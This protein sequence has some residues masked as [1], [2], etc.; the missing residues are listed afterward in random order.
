MVALVGV[1]IVLA[2]LAVLV[3][4]NFGGSTVADLQLIISLS[5]SSERERSMP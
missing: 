4:H 2:A 3:V 1:A 5:G